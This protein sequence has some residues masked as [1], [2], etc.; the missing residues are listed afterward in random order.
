MVPTSWGDWG[1]RPGPCS[2]GKSESQISTSRRIVTAT[3]AQNTIRV[4]ALWSTCCE[5]SQNIHIA[6][7]DSN[8][9]QGGGS[10]EGR[11]TDLTAPV[12][13][14]EPEDWGRRF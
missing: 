8:V 10:G 7:Q 4:A 12:L 11:G 9:F 2:L 14:L 5:T 1:W 6:A 13:G 3:S